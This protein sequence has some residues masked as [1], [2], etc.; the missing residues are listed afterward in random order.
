VYGG[1]WT[2]SVPPTHA[3]LE[4]ARQIILLQD[5]YNESKALSFNRSWQGYKDGFG[6]PQL[7]NFYIGRHA[8]EHRT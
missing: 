2:V 3:S 7:T 8:R 4:R 5:G 6:T 1:G